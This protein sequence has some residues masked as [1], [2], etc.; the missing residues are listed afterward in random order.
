[1]R[2]HAIA[3]AVLALMLGGGSSAA[4]QKAPQ[5]TPPTKTGVPPTPEEM[6]AMRAAVAL[7]QQGKFDEAIEQLTPLLDKNPDLAA[8]MYEIALCYQ[9]KKNYDKAMEFALKAADYNGE[10]LALTLALIGTALDQKGQPKDAVEFYR[11]AAALVPDPATIYYN[12]AV[13]YMSSLNQ[14]ADARDALKQAARANPKHASTQYMLARLFQTGGYPT[15]AFFALSRFLILEPGTNRTGPALNAWFQ[16]LRGGVSARP[17]GGVQVSVDPKAKTDE[18]DF[19]KFN[20][21]FSLSAVTKDAEGGNGGTEVQALAAQVDRLLGM[22][23]GDEGV[24][25]PKTFTG[26]YYTPYFTELKKKNFTEP[27]VYFLCQRTNLTGVRD[28]LTANRTRMQEFL[29]WNAAYVWPK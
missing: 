9:A 28:W 23:P 13:T 20:L 4:A 7:E 5:A 10:S 3:I 6:T 12:L 22:L 27:F 18:G 15:P 21:Y 16:M 24:N 11:G 17:D 26:T 25:D 1:M 29:A 14:P 2:R 19:T 8:A